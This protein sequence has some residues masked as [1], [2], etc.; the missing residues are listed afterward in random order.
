MRTNE[1]AN[2]HCCDLQTQKPE[3]SPENQKLTSPKPRGF[4]YA[5]FAVGEWHKKNRRYKGNDGFLIVDLSKRKS[6]RQPCPS[7]PLVGEP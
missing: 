2:N 7:T 4:G 1:L 5:R 6:L 3:Q